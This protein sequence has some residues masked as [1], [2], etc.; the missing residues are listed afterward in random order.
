MGHQTSSCGQGGAPIVGFEGGQWL[1]MIRNVIP[2]S[3]L[4]Q[5]PDSLLQ[6]AV[7]Q[8]TAKNAL[9]NIAAI[10]KYENVNGRN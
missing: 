3:N 9:K 7:Q 8:N 6:S 10:T 2:G 4:I 1:L 5:L